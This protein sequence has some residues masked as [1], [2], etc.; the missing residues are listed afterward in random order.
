MVR[1]G[2]DARTS[3]SVYRRRMRET[4]FRVLF[5]NLS[6]YSIPGYLKKDIER[7]QSRILKIIDPTLSYSDALVVF[8]LPTLAA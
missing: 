6:L 1:A 7:I 5:S 3:L 4:N 8:D 2:A